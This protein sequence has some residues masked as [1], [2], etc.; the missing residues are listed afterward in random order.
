MLYCQTHE[1]EYYPF[2]LK[3]SSFEIQFENLVNSNCM[4]VFLVKNFKVKLVLS[5]KDSIHVAEY[6]VQIQCTGISRQS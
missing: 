1:H 3:R 6:Y 2:A 4:T 5:P